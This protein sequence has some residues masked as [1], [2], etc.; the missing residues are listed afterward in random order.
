M[1]KDE[2]EKIL[3]QY[4]SP[5][6]RQHFVKM[7]YLANWSVDKKT[8]YGL[9]KKDTE[10]KP[11]GLKDICVKKDLYRIYH[12]FND[13]EVEIIRNFYKNDN[14]LLVASCEEELRKWQKQTRLSTLFKSIAPDNQRLIENFEIQSGE[15]FQTNYENYFM[16]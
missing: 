11:Y 1:N 5:T 3:K 15:W 2:A 12:N 8:I 6:R 10:Y 16:K 13:V 9:Y 7:E 4:Q 14:D